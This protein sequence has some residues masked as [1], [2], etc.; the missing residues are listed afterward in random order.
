[1]IYCASPG[2]F[3]NRKQLS[4]MLDECTKR[5]IFCALVCTNKWAGH[6]AQREAVMQDFQKLLERHHRATRDENGVIYCGN[7]G[8]CT[9]V[10]SER[11]E[12]EEAGRVF[13][14]SGVNELI[15]GIMES[16]DHEKMA[17]WCLLAFENK[18]FWKSVFNLGK[19]IKDFIKKHSK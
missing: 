12:D 3:A 10:N 16:L 7:M 2:S 8:L 13:E 18:P 6:K 4:W 17:Q 9:A 15:F 1:M 11:Y 19:R 5:Q 14:Q